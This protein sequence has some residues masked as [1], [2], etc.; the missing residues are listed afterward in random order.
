[1]KRS[2]RRS[3]SRAASNQRHFEESTMK[4][5]LIIATAALGAA[6]FAPA[7]DAAKNKPALTNL[8][9]VG[10][11]IADGNAA[12]PG[13]SYYLY[14]GGY[15]DNFAGATEAGYPSPGELAYFALFT[16]AVLPYDASIDNAFW[17]DSFNLQ[18]SRS[19]CYALVQFRVKPTGDLPSNDFLSM[20]H[21][22]PDGA[23]NDPI[24]KVG[25]PG[26]VTG[27]QTYALDA[28]G[29]AALSTVTGSASAVFDAVM[30]DDSSIDFFNLYVWYAN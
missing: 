23:T 15:N 13:S 19:V 16:N 30:E 18:N 28:T 8:T 9:K 29:L 22:H 10:N 2:R 1:M 24:A 26:A 6:L 21:F 3:G 11:K 5:A 27:I 7:A 4:T 20:V 25:Y 14:A 17:G 12:C